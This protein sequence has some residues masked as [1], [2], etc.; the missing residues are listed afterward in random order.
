MNNAFRDMGIG[1][2][3]A[4]VFVYLLMSSITRPGVTPSSSF[5]HYRRLSAAS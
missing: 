4:A 5:W 3:F 2:V 1:L